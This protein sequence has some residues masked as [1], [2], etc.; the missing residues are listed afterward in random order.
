MTE[1]ISDLLSQM[2]LREKIY[3]TMILHDTFIYDEGTT[4]DNLENTC[5]GGYFVGE[6]IIGGNAIK[7]DAIIE[8]VE[9]VNRY[10]KI[11]PIICADTEFGCGYM[12]PDGRYDQ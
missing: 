5:F 8:A 9:R 2:S 1:K 6:E 12:F 7:G 11:P 3:Q 10:S 4:K